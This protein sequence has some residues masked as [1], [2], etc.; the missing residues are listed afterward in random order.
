MISCKLQGGLGNYLFQVAAMYSLSEDVGFNIQD[1]TQV[2]GNIKKYLRNIFRKINQ[3]VEGLQYEYDEPSFTYQPLPTYNNILFN[4]YFQSEKYLDRIK[5]L[6]LY[7]IHNKAD[8]L[9]KMLEYTT[10]DWIALLDVDD[11]WKS[12]LNTTCVLQRDA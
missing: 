3:N 1:A 9:N 10:Y 7:T 4:G 11:K 2:H 6:D 12:K 5:I 8:A